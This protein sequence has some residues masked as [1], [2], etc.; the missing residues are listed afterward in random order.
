MRTDA[1][2]LRPVIGG[3]Y[4]PDFDPVSLDIG[5]WAQTRGITD[6]TPLPPEAA[7]LDRAL[8]E[9]G[10]LR[11]LCSLVA[12]RMEPALAFSTLR[13]S[14][15][16]LIESQVLRLRAEAKGDHEAGYRT[17]PERALRTCFDLYFASPCLSNSPGFTA[18]P[19][20]Q[21]ICRSSAAAVVNAGGSL[22]CGTVTEPGSD[23][24]SCARCSNA[25]SNLGA[26]FMNGVTRQV[27]IPLPRRR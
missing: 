6:R 2:L 15:Q 10:R 5:S 19:L 27:L 14:R 7:L 24:A 13:A 26:D 8:V 16:A 25:L 22:A 21:A 3:T 1:E 18:N 12:D 17:V 4:P 11:T 23:Q 20:E 9:I